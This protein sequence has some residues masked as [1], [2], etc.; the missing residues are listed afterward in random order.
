MTSRR[1]F[2]VLGLLLSALLHGF[3]RAGPASLAAALL[4]TPGAAAPDAPRV[5][6]VEPRVWACDFESR[7]LARPM[8]FL[9]VLPA[10][11][12]PGAARVPVVYF[13]HGRGRHE[14]TL[15]ENEVTRRVVL[16]ARFAIVLPRGQDGWY[17]NAPAAPADRFGDYLDEVLAAAEELFP[18]SREA[19]GRA[20]G[21]WSM[22]GYGATYTAGRR[23]G[24]FAAVAS[25]IGVI[26]FPRAPV[27]EPKQNYAVPARFGTDPDA[28]RA[29][30]PRLLLPRLRGTPYFVA[31]ADQAFERQ[32]N[33]VFIADARA[34]GVEVEV[35]RLSGGHTFPMVEQA[36]PAALAFFD[37]R[38]FPAAPR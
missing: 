32:M 9:V 36:L 2:L 17:V 13:L 4:A 27:G 3:S 7:A 20:I 22:G 31:Y 14:H 33:E 25:L 29:F 6:V 26:D 5:S 30:N 11:T 24:D 34:V 35:L 38:L 28:W 23:A 21:G 19:A 8:R 12:A 10:G 1:A 15:L 16:A 37:R 18:V